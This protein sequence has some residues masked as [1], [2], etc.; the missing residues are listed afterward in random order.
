MKKDYGNENK[1]TG[2]NTHGTKD[3]RECPQVLNLQRDLIGRKM[4]GELYQ[5]QKEGGGKCNQ[6]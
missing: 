5:P 1:K 2:G 6:D 4:G 3:V